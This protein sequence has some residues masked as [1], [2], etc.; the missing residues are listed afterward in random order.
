MSDAAA[1]AALHQ[2]TMSEAWS[3][4][5]FQDMLSLPT[6]IGWKISSQHHLVAF[7]LLQETYQQAEILSLATHPQHRRCGM[8]QRLLEHASR[9][10]HIKHCS[11]VM[12]ELRAGNLAAYQ[13]YVSHGFKPQSTRKHYYPDGEDALT[14]SLRMGNT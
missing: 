8:A 10:L 14:M 6:T 12:L 5:S 9:E 4:Q 3:V 2:E 11:R 13:L 7:I 1:L